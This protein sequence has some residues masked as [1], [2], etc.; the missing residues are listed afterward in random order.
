MDPELKSLSVNFMKENSGIVLGS[1]FLSTISDVF[2]NIIVPKLLA[3][4][5]K[6]VGQDDLK[7]KVTHFVGG[8]AIEKILH[9]GSIYLSN[10]IEPSLHHYILKELTKAVIRKYQETGEPIQVAVIMEKVNIIS[11]ALDSTIHYMCFRLL[12]LIFTLIIA[13]VSIFKVNVKLGICVTICMILFGLLLCK[14]NYPRNVDKL[15][16]G[17]LD[18][19]EDAFYN[20][21]FIS[22]SDSGVEQIQREIMEKSDKF[23]EHRIN[24][25]KKHTYT[26]GYGYMAGVGFYFA[27]IYYMYN[28]K[29]RGEISNDDFSSYIIILGKIYGVAFNLAY[30]VPQMVKVYRTM[31]STRDFLKKLYETTPKRD[32]I[33]LEDGSLVLKDVSFKYPSSPPGEEIFNGLNMT[34]ESGSHVYLIGRSGSGKSTFTNLVKGREY[35]TSG[36]VIVGNVA[37]DKTSKSVLFSQIGSVNQNTNSLLKRSIYENIIFGLEDTP[38]LRTDVELYVSR[39]G[40]NK[41]FDRNL[42]DG[43]EPDPFSF[44]DYV[45]G[46]SSLSLS[47]GQKQI[48]HLLHAAFQPNIKVLIL[49]EPTSALDHQTRNNVLKM[50]DDINKRGITIFHITHD[51]EVQ[52]EASKI[53]SFTRGENPTYIVKE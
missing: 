7:E 52:D 12:P 20:I 50:I 23:H 21:E 16:E 15:K 1:V 10:Q 19:V 25:Y 33:S 5:I 39:Y 2:D 49:D 36:E 44:L 14:V 31:N 13:L 24:Y 48:I 17:V 37:T 38:A 47:G 43:V 46:E 26:Q 3:K 42:D 8:I 30:Y 22:S 29:Q 27:S 11:K 28:L 41:V 40:I 34:I 9:T 32:D 53:I 51:T 4:V 18:S 6:S 45:I 35:P